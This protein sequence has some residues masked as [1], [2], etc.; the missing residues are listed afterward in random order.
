MKSQQFDDKNLYEKKIIELL[1]TQIILLLSKNNI[2]ILLKLLKS[3]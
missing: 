1:H 2:K 3:N